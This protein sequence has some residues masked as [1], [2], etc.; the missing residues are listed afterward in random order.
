METFVIVFL[1]LRFNCTLLKL[2]TKL[3]FFLFAVF[4]LLLK[5]WPA[6]FLLLSNFYILQLLAL[7]FFIFY[8]WVGNGAVC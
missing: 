2:L 3:V 4:V 5:I 6:T 8:F 1:S 7:Q